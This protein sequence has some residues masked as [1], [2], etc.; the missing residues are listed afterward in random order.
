MIAG[1]AA[2]QIKPQSGERMQP[3]AQTLRLAENIKSPA[4]AK[5][6]LSF[7]SSL[8]DLIVFNLTQGSRPGLYALATFGAI[9]QA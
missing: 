1:R 8:R 5:D 2:I 3:R 9:K 6:Q 4:A 7:L